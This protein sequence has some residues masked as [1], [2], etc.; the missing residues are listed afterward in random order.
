MKHGIHLL[1]M[2]LVLARPALAHKPSDS[3]LTLVPDGHSVRVRWDIALRDLDYALA[4]DAN[5]DGDLTGREL[6]QR[7]AEVSAYA[8]ER[9]ALSAD[10]RTCP[11]S[12]VETR[13]TQHSDGAY[14]AL[15]FEAACSRA[16][17]TLA[18]RYR[19]FFE[20]DPQHRGLVR[21]EVDGAT[22]TG[23]LRADA[24]TLGFTVAEA[25]PLRQFVAMTREGV[26]HIWIGIDHILF[27]LALL[28]P[29]VFQ[30]EEGRWRAAGAFRPVFMEVLKVVTS[31]TVAHS[32]TLGLATLGIVQLPSRWVETA[33]ALS[34]VLAALNNLRPMLLG[35]WRL[36]FALGL[37]H[38][39]GFSSVLA[40]LGLSGGSVVMSLL[41]FNF[42]V[43][44]GQA[45]VVAVFLPT[46]FLLR[47]T[48]T[49]RALAFVGG[50][51]CIALTAGVWTVE[52]FFF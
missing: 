26:W 23:V 31:F 52:R 6:R 45:A 40:D 30:R 25:E 44:L 11:L 33:I 29:A 18:V 46:A 9:L 49:Y 27:L 13:L 42:G 39:F 48:W 7:S 12:P 50:S 38:G 41:A 36:A 19:L 22:R 47:R 34:V 24:D 43:E 21:L 28:L 32:L 14:L 10:Q 17:S 35:R 8:L 4:L 20:L 16:P 3:Y 51:A 15:L 2:L 1:W 37:L 5:A